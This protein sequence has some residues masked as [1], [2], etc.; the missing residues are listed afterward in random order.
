MWVVVERLKS[1]PQL[2][3]RIP[4]TS[5][6]DIGIGPGER[7]HSRLVDGIG[8][9]IHQNVLADGSGG[10][11]PASGCEGEQA[12]ENVMSAIVETARLKSRPKIFEQGR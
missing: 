9:A 10:A 1:I 11:R 7:L 8:V 6:S 2:G 12:A 4:P 3:I 5:A